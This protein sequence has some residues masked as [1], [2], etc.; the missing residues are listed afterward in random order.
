MC[1]YGSI[2]SIGPQQH[3]ID[4]EHSQAHEKVKKNNGA[5]GMEEKRKK[6]G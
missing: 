5:D 6:G 1:K 4:D 3:N 2:Y